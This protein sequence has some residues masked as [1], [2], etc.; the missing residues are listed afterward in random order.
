MFGRLIEF[1]D[2]SR[3]YPVRA[4]V[5]SEEPVTK[6]WDCK[7]TLDQK[8]DGS[9]VS[10]AWGHELIAEPTELLWVDYPFCKEKVYWE[11]QKID[12]F[13]GGAYPGANPFME[14]TSV[15][16]GAK[17]LMRLGLI[18][19]YRWAFGLDDLII[20]VGHYGPA[21][22]G[23]NWY[24][25]MQEPD[26]WGRIKVSGRVTGGHAVLVRGVNVD[27]ELFTLRNSWGKNYGKNGDCFLSFSDMWRLLEERGEACFAL[28]R[29]NVGKPV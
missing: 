8:V 25:G 12:K 27:K 2:S 17:V 5:R 23:V 9:C 16:A 19:N 18:D 11:A 26:C 3:Q 13:P 21:V 15:L 4:A 14:G 1:D 29:K 28:G 24:S 20:G 10:C 7:I 6:H 22:I